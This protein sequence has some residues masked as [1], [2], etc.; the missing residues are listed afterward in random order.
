MKALRPAA[1]AL[2]LATMVVVAVVL[3]ARPSSPPSAPAARAAGLASD[4]RCPVCQGLSVANSPSPAARDIRAD[5]ARRIE[6]GQTDPEIRQ[7]YVD[8]YGD[9]ILL[10]PRGTGVAAMVWALP[11]AAVVVAAAGLALALR[12]WRHQPDGEPSPED[13]ELVARLRAGR[14][15]GGG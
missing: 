14:G 12:R 10:R 6:A 4:L 15:V 8:R 9:W 7:A 13:R 1:G 11:V 3:A 2:V 5:I